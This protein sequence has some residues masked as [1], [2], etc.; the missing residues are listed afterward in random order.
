MI[1][2]RAVHDVEERYRGSMI[3]KGSSAPVSADEPRVLHESIAVLP[4]QRA[5]D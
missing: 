2:K 5:E 3:G 1:R 4:Y